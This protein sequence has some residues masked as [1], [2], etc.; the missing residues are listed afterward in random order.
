[1]KNITINKQDINIISIHIQPLYNAKQLK[2]TDFSSNG[3]T[4]KKSIH[5]RHQHAS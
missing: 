1:M 2:V 4:T 5:N 3:R